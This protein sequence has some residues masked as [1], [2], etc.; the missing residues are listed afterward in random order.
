MEELLIKEENFSIIIVKFFDQWFKN[1]PQLLWILNIYKIVDLLLV[2]RWF[3][4][5]INNSLN[6]G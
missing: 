5:W 1:N 6:Y 3:N 2:K 4:E